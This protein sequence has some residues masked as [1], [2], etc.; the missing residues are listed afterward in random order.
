MVAVGLALDDCKLKKLLISVIHRQRS[1]LR[2]P[3]TKIEWL[4]EDDIRRI[5]KSN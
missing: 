1:D 2:D 3:T 4:D 5:R